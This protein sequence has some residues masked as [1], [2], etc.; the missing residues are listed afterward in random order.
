[1]AIGDVLSSAWNGVTGAV[2]SA[3]QGLSLAGR[4]VRSSANWAQTEVN[5]GVN[6]ADRNVDSGLDA[7]THSSL[8]DNFVG[9]G[10]AD[11]V[12]DAVHFTGGLVKGVTGLGT[13]LV[14]LAGMSAQLNGG[15]LQYL[16]DENYR[17]ETNESVS[18]F[19]HN[20]AQDPGAIPRTLAQNVA[21]AWRKDPAD[22]LGQGTA[23]AGSFVAGGML[24]GLGRGGAVLEG[25]TDLA[26]A[27]Q[28]T[29]VGET[30]VKA[31]AAE[32][33]TEAGTQGATTATQGATTGTQG[34][35]T[36]TQTGTAVGAKPVP[37]VGASQVTPASVR[38]SSPLKIPDDANIIQQDKA[39][40][41]NQ[42]KFRWSDGG[43]NYEARWH[44][45]T[46]GAPA[47][48][49]PSWVV[50]RTTPGTAAGTPRTTEIL[51]GQT[52][53]PGNT[54]FAA[55]AARKAGTA[56]PAQ[57]ALLDSGHFPAH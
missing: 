53:T 36:G 35:T 18:N 27:G 44:T 51:T 7:F 30:L 9:R 52:W 6:W 11:N 49:G 56:T 48:A 10:I 26:D 29:E 19:A 16:T 55:V 32:Q 46:P 22:F 43:Q 40:G 2:D 47:N 24:A 33:A 38:G 34:A 42:M 3:G 5:D 31:G 28:G 14:G 23:I 37:E 4:A 15:T 21:D 17:N 41:Y 25:A 8:G 50:T 57:Q 13:G 12:H 1:M 45:R 54:W 39:A 20:F